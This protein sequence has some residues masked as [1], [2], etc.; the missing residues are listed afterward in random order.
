MK[1]VLISLLLISA[2]IVTYGCSSD[3]VPDGQ[4]IV[5]SSNNDAQNGSNGKTD[6]L[7]TDGCTT[8]QDGT[9]KD[10]Q[11]NI[12]ETGYDKWGYNYQAH[13][14]NGFYDNYTRPGTLVTSGDN[15][16]MKWNDLWLSNKDCNGDGK[17][18]RGCTSPFTNSACPGAWC[19]NHMSGVDENGNEWTY[20]VKIICPE[21]SSYV[22]NGYY[23][24][25]D[26]VEIG[27]AIWGSFAIVEEIQT[28]DVESKYKSP[29]NPGFGTYKE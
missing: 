29:F 17:L 16:V 19:T 27:P 1:Q 8:I 3:N 13:I 10:S 14:F 15:L 23:Y 12:L 21:T 25:K 22:E 28:G 9:L 2:L 26:G 24:T 20:F 18:D 7:T 11:G 6:L 4:T 5:S